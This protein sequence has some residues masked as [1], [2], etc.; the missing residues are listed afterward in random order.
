MIIPDADA[1]A[2]YY[3]AKKEKENEI[4][5]R[6][7]PICMVCE[8]NIGADRCYRVYDNDPEACICE[9]CM[10]GQIE[11]MRRANINQGL[12][13]ALNDYIATMWGLTPEGRY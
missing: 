10:E 9:S 4:W 3:F 13:D 7:R 12:R 8:E 1:Q 11:K 2:D 6:R 5:L